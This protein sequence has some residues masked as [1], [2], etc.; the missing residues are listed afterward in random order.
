LCI[1]NGF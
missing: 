1:W